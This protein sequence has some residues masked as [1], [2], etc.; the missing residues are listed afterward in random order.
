M[1]S[2]DVHVS[3]LL[4]HLRNEIAT[5]PTNHLALVNEHFKIVLPAGFVPLSDFVPLALF[6]AM[7][8]ALQENSL[9]LGVRFVFLLCLCHCSVLP[10]CGFVN[11]GG[12]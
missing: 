7:G 2:R 3:S 4:A 10:V 6:V 8:N 12:H 11:C 5:L 9:N 1:P